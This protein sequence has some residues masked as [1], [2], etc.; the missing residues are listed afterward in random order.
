M[1][2]KDNLAES[3]NNSGYTDRQISAWT[4]ISTPVISNMS[5]KKHD[6]LKVDQF[7]KLRLLF[8][9]E[10]EDFL[11]KIFGTNYFSKITKIEQTENLTPLGEIL[12]SEYHFEELPK[13]ELCKATGLLSS[14]VNYIVTKEDEQIKIDEI[15]KVELALGLT[16]GT[17]V[18]KRFRIKLNTQKQYEARLKELKDKE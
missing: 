17:L 5:N 8:K 2:W 12:T 4:N 15:T 13:K 18:K 14:R 10:H 9:E 3:I 1:S 16:V 11:Y 6:S 7:V